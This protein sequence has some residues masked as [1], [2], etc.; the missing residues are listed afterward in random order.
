LMGIILQVLLVNIFFAFFKSVNL[1]A[2][3]GTWLQSDKLAKLAAIVIVTFW[4][5]WVNT[6][7][8]WRVTDVE[9]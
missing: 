9:K 8:S 2:T 3:F 1:E 6:K 4:N 5:Y 7:L